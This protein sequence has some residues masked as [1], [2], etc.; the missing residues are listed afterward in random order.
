MEFE[1]QGVIQEIFPLFENALGEKGLKLVLD[2]PENL[3][4]YAD[5]N[6]IITIIRN[7]LTNAIKFTESG[8]IRVEARE[9]DRYFEIKV[10][11]S[12]VGISQDRLERIFDIDK[13]KTTEGTRNEPGTGLGLLICKDFVEK[14]GGT[15]GVESKEGEG[16]TFYFRIPRITG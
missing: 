8:I 13:S 7:L 2:I 6:M 10:T 15:I 4:I 14:H 1:I 11:D 12:G 5:R 16:S 3:R 9:Y